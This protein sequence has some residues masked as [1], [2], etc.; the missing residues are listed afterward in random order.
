MPDAVVEKIGSV[1]D[2]IDVVATDPNA[3]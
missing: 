1:Q 3:K 2:I